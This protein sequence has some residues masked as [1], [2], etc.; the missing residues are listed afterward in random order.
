MR[1][2]FLLIPFLFAMT[3]SAAP[4][5]LPAI[6]TPSGYFIQPPE[7]TLKNVHSLRI[8]DFQKLIGRKLTLKEKISFLLLKKK[9]RQIPDEKEKGQTA[10]ILGIMGLGLLI[11]GLFVPYVILGSLVLSIMAIVLGTIEKKKNPSD[12]KAKAGA[13]LG[14]ITLSLIAFLLLLAAI[15]LASWSFY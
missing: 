11:I 2:Y 12:S 7:S 8:K 14:W 15:V 10:F 9:L 6:I 4:F 5:S 3:A 1:K 13:L